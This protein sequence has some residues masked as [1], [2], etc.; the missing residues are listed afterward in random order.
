[1]DRLRA[2]E[3]V[4]AHLGQ[5]ERAD[6]PLRDQLGHRAPRL[7][8]RHL[9]IDA[10]QLVEVD[11][12]GPQ[13]LSE[14]SIASRTCSGRPSLRSTYSATSSTTSPHLVASTTS[15]RRPSI[16]RPTSSSFV[17][18]PYMSAVSSR[19][20][21]MSSARWMVAIDSASSRSASP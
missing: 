12:V 4:D 18:G 16:A 20:T 2:L 3:L 11:E 15:S 10:V 7:L 19:V 14:P 5:A 17:Y 1:M 9:G 8:E 21:P 6:L 13:P